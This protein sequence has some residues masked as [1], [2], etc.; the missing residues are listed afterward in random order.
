MNVVSKRTLRA[1][2]DKHANS[3]G[4]LSA[5][6]DSVS[7]EQWGSPNDIKKHHRSADFVGDKSYLISVA[8]NI[9]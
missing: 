2:W 3:Q 6:H 9:D 4:P 8:I 5:W 7:K 1:Y